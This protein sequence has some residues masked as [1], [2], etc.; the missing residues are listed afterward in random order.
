MPGDREFRFTEDDYN[1]LAGLLKESTGISLAGHKSDM[2]YARLVRRVRP[3]G[4]ETFKDYIN[5][6]NGPDGPEEMSHLVN[7][8][9]TNL[10]RFFREPYHFDHLNEVSLKESLALIDIGQSKRL[11]IWSAGCSTGEEAYS[12]AMVLS[13]R[14][15]NH[16][17]V[18]AKIL[19]TDLDTN[20]LTTAAE[21]IYSNKAIETIPLDYRTNAVK[22]VGPRKNQQW[23][24]RNRLK[25]L[26]PFRR[27]NLIEPWPMSG[28][29]DIIFCRN[30]MIYFDKETTR[31]I[32]DK[33]IDLL[34]PGGWLYIG[35]SENI[36]GLDHRLRR[37]AG[38]TYQKVGEQM[39]I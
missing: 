24:I 14:L 31:Q 17:L 38:T 22:P 13:K 7:A 34:R 5:Y 30:V 27:L 20:V 29:F 37:E 1:Y 10:T 25:E 32:L 8:L 12:I 26:I 4:L 2:V 19:A 9:T 11:R 23:Q 6:L 28:P 16:P 18:D 21:G 33:F 35:H 3:L 15:A 36:I 39:W